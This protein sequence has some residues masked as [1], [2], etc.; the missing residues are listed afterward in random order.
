MTQALT[1]SASP[2]MASS[3]TGVLAGRRAAAYVRVST[4]KQAD[5]ELSLAEQ[6]EEIR[7]WAEANGVEL[8]TTFVEE[9]ASG[10]TDR[11]P[12]LQRM[13]R[14]IGSGAL[15][16]DLVLVWS[17]SRF[18]RNAEE[19]AAYKLRLARHG[20]QLQSVTQDF[21]TGPHAD[22]I[23]QILT[24]IDQY[25]SQINAEQVKLVMRANAEQGW[26][27]GSRPPFGYQAA[28]DRQVGR[29]MK[30]RLVPDPDE[31]AVVV[32][33]F[34][35]YAHGEEGSGP[36]GLKAIAS[37]LN[38][39][40]VRL[41][42]KRFLTSTI[43][44][45]LQRTTYIGEHLYNVRD[46]RTG[47][48]RPPEEWI[49][50]PCPPIVE[51]PL[52]E[53]VQARLAINRPKVTAPRRVNGP[54]LL[55]QIGRCGEPGCGAGLLLVTGKGGRYRYLTCQTKRTQAAD[56]CTLRN[57]R[58]ADVDDAVIAA[59]E[60]RILGPERLRELLHHLLDRSDAAR[61]ERASR[62]SRLRARRTEAEATKARL[63][64]AIEAGLAD[65]R[66][67]EVRQR[68]EARNLELSV[69]DEEIRALEAQDR[70]RP[71]RQITPDVLD[72]FARLMRE[73][74][75]GP[76]PHLRK[77]Y[78]HM[79]VSEVRLSNE[80]LVIR[81]HT[82][83]LEVMVARSAESDRRLVPT[84]AQRWRTR[85]DSNLWPLPSEGNALSS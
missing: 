74:L 80:G 75:R 45:I 50:I 44:D 37:R 39:E 14:E 33:I 82:S 34:R 13:V 10:T 69:L 23:L 5:N 27:N 53:A 57:F 24:A 73:A 79:L 55:G 68:L 40:G 35:L 67:P 21:G 52:F 58:L 36:Q 81:G 46:S 32:R 70:D 28:P 83:D 77:S 47:R 29:K 11:R 1:A 41:R 31:A 43:A 25:A 62:L 20:V 17:Y 63:W 78:L 51:R 71:H 7:A 4:R 22:L 3:S 38:G 56:A 61:A 60:Q 12:Q 84:F 42:G 19:F 72:R 65:P 9:G 30:K 2:I 59:I 85:E 66:D 16:V 48:I 49:R 15:R 54:T 8:V 76:D 18:F 6:Q 26:W 64:D